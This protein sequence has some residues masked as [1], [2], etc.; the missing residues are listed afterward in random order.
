MNVRLLIISVLAAIP[1][2][3]RPQSKAKDTH[4]RIWTALCPDFVRVQFAGSVG[5]VSVGTGWE[6]G[7]RQRWETDLMAGYL[8]A[9][10]T[11]RSSLTVTLRQTYIPW[12]KP[13][14]DG[15]ALKPLTCGLFVNTICNDKFWV[16]Q[17]RQYRKNYWDIET[18][19]RSSVFVGQ[20]WT[21]DLGNT[22]DR[23]Y[24]DIEFDYALSVCDLY[25]VSI[26]TNRSRHIWQVLSL[27]IGVKFDF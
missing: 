10:A 18:K 22:P 4:D 13:L 14:T 21:F 5:V 6:C 9:F 8:P 23:L 15:I 19:I 2:A 25:F 26:V 1:I 24:R 27:S 11:D 3:A 12:R 16:K 20:R 7:Q 17:P